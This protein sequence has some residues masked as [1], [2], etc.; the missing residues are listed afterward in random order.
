MSKG[1]QIYSSNTYSAVV[2]HALFMLRF[3]YA[4]A[5]FTVLLKSLQDPF[6]PKQRGDLPGLGIIIGCT[7]MVCLFW[8]LPWGTQVEHALGLVAGPDV[9]NVY[10]FEEGTMNACI[11]VMVL[12]FLLSFT[13]KWP[14]SVA[15][16]FAATTTFILVRIVGRWKVSSSA[17]NA[18]DFLYNQEDYLYVYGVNHFGICWVLQDQDGNNAAFWLSFNFPVAFLALF[19][20]VVSFL[21]HVMVVSYGTEALTLQKR[22][23]LVECRNA[24]I[25]QGVTATAVFALFFFQF[26]ALPGFGW[27]ACTRMS[28]CFFVTILL[29]NEGSDLVRETFL[30][31][32]RSAEKK[33]DQI[34][35]DQQINDGMRKHLFGLFLDAV[36]NPQDEENDRLVRESSEQF[37]DLRRYWGL[38]DH[39]GRTFQQLQE[40]KLENERIDSE[41]QHQ[42]LYKETTDHGGA[43]GSFMF[44]PVNTNEYIVKTISKEEAITL[45]KKFLPAYHARIVMNRYPHRCPGCGAENEISYEIGILKSGEIITCDNC[46]APYCSW[47]GIKHSMDHEEGGCS[48]YERDLLSENNRRSTRMGSV[49]GEGG[50]STGAATAAGYRMS[51]GRPSGEPLSPLSPRSVR[52]SRGGG[53]VEVVRSS[54]LN[55]L[56]E[57]GGG[58][59]GVS[60]LL[61]KQLGIYKVQLNMLQQPVYFQVMEN[62]HKG[63]AH[64]GGLKFDLKGSHNKGK[65]GEP[66]D[67]RDAEMRSLLS[68]AELRF[69]LD[70]PDDFQM[71]LA[72]DVATLRSVGLM[73]YSLLVWALKPEEQSE[74]ELRGE[75]KEYA[76]QAAECLVSMTDTIKGA[77]ILLSGTRSVEE[78]DRNVALCIR[79]ANSLNESL[80]EMKEES[81]PGDESGTQA[82]TFMEEQGGVTF[83]TSSTGSTS[84]ETKV[85]ADHARKRSGGKVRELTDKV[86]DLLV[87]NKP[88]G[89]GMQC[90]DCIYKKA[91]GSKLYG[92]ERQIENHMERLKGLERTLHTVFSQIPPP[93]RSRYDMLI[94]S[95]V[96][97]CF[98][99][100]EEFEVAVGISDVATLWGRY[101]RV[102]EFGKLLTCHTSRTTK[103]LFFHA[104]D[105]GLSAKPPAVFATRFE[106]ALCIYFGC[107]KELEES[108]KARCCVPPKR[109]PNYY[110]PQDAA[111][112]HTTPGPGPFLGAQRDGD[113]NTALI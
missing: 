6:D 87:C 40:M 86:R 111:D 45:M 19:G 14:H 21:A 78:I 28:S 94:D 39:F 64:P 104:N 52:E 106:E 98:Y 3:G 71:R 37:R 8:K 76:S 41:D 93:K 1:N 18:E 17:Q 48:D 32:E 82:S 34:K 47:H 23:F 110:C 80:H 83:R 96:G 42:S 103:G 51:H 65:T 35:E 77:A 27:N 44:F 99:M 36:C 59:T 55:S 54:D 97:K 69:E 50:R 88:R 79:E 63:I 5:Q 26:V 73:D 70:D 11:V 33:E 2:F 49:L 24:A 74:Q 90:V 72:A 62:V 105:W 60:S 56:R 67:Y 25:T 75:I 89:C 12:A 29:F 7:I 20:T 113:P 95:K 101:Q 30:F 16:V 108:E 91:K 68:S 9:H 84:F 102:T 109:P 92:L 81:Q 43:S 66:D 107:P 85:A 22:K 112:L 58:E 4:L 10:H 31:Y 15:L 38:D 53:Y 61:V 100:G 57:S 46:Q 13:P